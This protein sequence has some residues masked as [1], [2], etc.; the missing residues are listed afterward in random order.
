MENIY[1]ESSKIINYL[2]Q[3]AE[4]TWDIVFYCNHFSNMG[5]SPTKRDFFIGKFL[6]ISYL[7][8]KLAPFTL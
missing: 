2:A 7:E 8:L 5:Y 3:S 4:P 1:R 6:P